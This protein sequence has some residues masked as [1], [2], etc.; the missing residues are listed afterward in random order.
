M[1]IVT[2]PV[3]IGPAIGRDFAHLIVEGLAETASGMPTFGNEREAILTAARLMVA[4]QYEGQPLTAGESL[5]SV[6]D[7]SV[8]TSDAAARASL[9]DVL[10]EVALS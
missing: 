2:G 3:P 1:A 7:Q 4:P 5:L 10:R 8:E 6:I 9:A